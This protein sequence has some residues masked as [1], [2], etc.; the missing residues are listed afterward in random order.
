MSKCSDLFWH[1]GGGSMGQIMKICLKDH[2]LFFANKTLPQ[3][4]TC[5]PKELKIKGDPWMKKIFFSKKFSD[6]S[7][8]RLK[9]SEI[10]C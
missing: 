4:D 8:N 3:A 5:R 1:L 6:F 9:R 2:A 7:W 10:L